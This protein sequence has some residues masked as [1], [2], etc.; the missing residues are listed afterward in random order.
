[1]SNTLFITDP[2]VRRDDAM[3]PSRT[4]I[5]PAVE[6]ITESFD[7]VACL[8]ERVRYG[9]RPLE[10]VAP[11]SYVQIQGPDRTLLVELD[12]EV[13]HIGRGLSA[14]LHLADASVSRRHA[15]LVSRPSGHRILDDRSFNGTFVNGRRIE[16][17]D[18]ASGDVIVLGRVVLR[19]LEYGPRRM[20][21]RLSLGGESPTASGVL[22]SDKDRR[23]RTP[24][25]RAAG[26]SE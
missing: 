7:P 9:G 14:D 17:F 18:L 12:A 13:T 23:P 19:Y 21:G 11:G 16:Q 26:V 6:E 25:R 3:D 1:M 8:D 15:I 5:G 20:T 10:P 24:A 4:P 2:S 22:S